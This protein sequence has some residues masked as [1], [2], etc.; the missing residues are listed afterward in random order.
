MEYVLHLQMWTT[1]TGGG[2]SWPVARSGHS[3]V[4][5]HHPGSDFIPDPAVMVMWGCTSGVVLSD[6]WVFQ[7]NARQ[8]RKVLTQTCMQLC[9]VVLSS[10]LPYA[11]Y[12]YV[13][14][15]ALC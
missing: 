5:L 12:V 6:C 8:W 3:A 2:P 13:C 9:I 14:S 7:V 4:S 11:H 15:R 1:I 10:D